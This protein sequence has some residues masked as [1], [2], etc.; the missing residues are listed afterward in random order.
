MKIAL[1]GYGKMGHEIEIV[2][3]ARNHQVSLI[4]DR[5]NQSDLTIENIK[6]VDVAIEFST[7]QTAFNNI[8]ICIEAGVPIVAGTTGWVD[9]LG[10]AKELLKQSNGSLFYASNYS[11]GVNLYF[12]V[13]KLLAHY[14]DSIKGYSASI[15]EIHHTQKLDAPSGTAIT[16][17]QVISSSI[18]DMKGWTLLPEQE[19]G[20]IPIEA[21]R[22]GTVPGTHVVTYDSDQDEIIFTHRAKNRKGF[23]IGAVLAAEH[24]FNK[25]GFFT[26]DDLL[27]IE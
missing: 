9:K 3:L 18:S 2:A 13:N 23:A 1:I 5:D 16:L 11:I 10:E 17:A 26:M 20:K 6:N 12:K 22:E 25:Q 14:I 15:K 7:P 4:I 21:V 19:D 24:I 27:K 8:K